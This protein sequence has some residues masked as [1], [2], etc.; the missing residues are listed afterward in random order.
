MPNPF[1][2]GIDRREFLKASVAI[3]GTAALSGCL[4][5]FDGND[6]D[7]EMPD[8]PLEGT[9]NH[10]ELPNRQFAWNDYQPDDGHGNIDLADHHVLLHL[11]Y[12][13]G[14]TPSDDDREK[15]ENALQ[16][17]EKAYDWSSYG[18]LFTVGYSRSYFDKYDEEL[19]D[20]I[21]LPE[22]EPFSSFESP[23]F[24][25]NDIFLHLASDFAEPVV[26]AE[27]ALF[28]E[29]SELN[30]HEVEHTI[31][32]I[33]EVVDRRTGFHSAGMPAEKAPETQN[34][35]GDGPPEA[36]PTFM[37]FKA[38][39]AESQAT[40]DYIAFDD[41]VFEDGTTEH[42][43]VLRLHLDQWFEQESFTQQVGQMF[44][45]EHANEDL[46][47]GVGE[48]LGDNAEI[49][50]RDLPEKAFE[51]AQGGM[52]GHAQ[53]A[54]RGNRD[55]DGN[56]IT[57]RRDFDSTDDNRATFHFITLQETISQFKLVRE[58][59]N[60]EDLAETTSIGQRMN[61]GILQYITTERRGN[62]LI[63]PR[64]HRSFPT[65]NPD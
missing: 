62:F 55:E 42:A 60:G 29:L 13:G 48:N 40:E 8:S 1:G 64:E 6:E 53:K 20:S 27:E 63:P 59:M 14:G 49:F 4:D 33:I 32:D 31:E 43:S 41:G 34:V 3:G 10:D 38:G 19:P 56:P 17:L 12:I 65:P 45:P 24:D 30:G 11:D 2:G 44:S 25:T 51:H 7:E 28:G 52:V 16:E 57:L 18:L 37:G 39:F 5:L 61:N 22:P 35:P 9:D 36:S 15:L 23:E 26:A 46:V 54:A 47:D 21:D 58:A 50:D